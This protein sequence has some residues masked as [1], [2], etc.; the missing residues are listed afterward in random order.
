MSAILW[1]LVTRGAQHG[2]REVKVPMTSFTPSPFATSVDT[3]GSETDSSAEARRGASSV[4][5]SRTASARS[6][7]DTDI[8]VVDGTTTGLPDDTSKVE[9]G[10]AS[11]REGGEEGGGAGGR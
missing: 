6:A 2:W 7:A 9:I 1:M 4:S 11:C 10:R 3:R 5:T 8:P